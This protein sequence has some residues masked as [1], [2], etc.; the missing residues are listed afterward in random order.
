MALMYVATTKTLPTIK[1]VTP[2]D[3]GFLRSS[4]AVLGPELGP[5]V[6]GII[7][8]NGQNYA[9]AVHEIL[10]ARHPSGTPKFIEWPL[11]RDIEEY[12]KEVLKSMDRML[13]EAA[14]V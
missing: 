10:T 4:N 6:I 12:P 2:I 7:F 11:M 1:M 14:D 3:K 13:A 9:A 8:W 5:G